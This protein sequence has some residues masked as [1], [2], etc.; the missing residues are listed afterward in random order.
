MMRWGT[1]ELLLNNGRYELALFLLLTS[2]PRLPGLEFHT[3]SWRASHF[4][5]EIRNVTGWDGW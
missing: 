2:Q 3:P 4:L 1:A 5:A